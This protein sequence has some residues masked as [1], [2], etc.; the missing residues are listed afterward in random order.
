MSRILAENAGLG[1]VTGLCIGSTAQAD[2]LTC[3][4]SF[5]LKGWSVIYKTAKGHGTVT[6][7]DGSSMKV[8]LSTKGGGPT[9]IGRGEVSLAITG[10]GRGFDV[11]VDLGEFTISEVVP[12]PAPAPAPAPK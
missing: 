6:C 11:G 5:T 10:T 8:H 3:K 7:S 1:L 2:D 4:M 9:V 12:K